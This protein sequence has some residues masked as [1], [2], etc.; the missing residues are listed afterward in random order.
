MASGD[1][2]AVE[3]QTGFWSPAR[4]RLATEGLQPVLMGHT[5]VQSADPG[6][7]AG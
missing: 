3:G 6:N 5:P 7:K 1:T 2:L 4:A